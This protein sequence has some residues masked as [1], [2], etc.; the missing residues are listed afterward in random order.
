M[1]KTIEIPDELYEQIKDQLCE[2]GATEINGWADMVGTKLFLRTVTYH[3]IGK[4]EAVNGNLMEL[5]GASWVASSGRFM[6]AIKDGTLLEVEPVGRA[7][8][9]L[10]SVTDC[11][12]WKHELPKA[13][14]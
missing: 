10:A 6:Q 2:G 5:S 14:K 13:Q 11:F 3:L 4:V 9:N 1:P 12:P 7:W 8:V